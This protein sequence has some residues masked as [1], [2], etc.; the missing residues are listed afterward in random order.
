MSQ[1]VPAI[2][3]DMI[4][5]CEADIL[6]ESQISRFSYSH[7]H[8]S[9]FPHILILGYLPLNNPRVQVHLCD[10]QH[11]SKFQLYF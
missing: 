8:S 10:F 6:L 1:D 9:R 5:R 7:Y 2:W 4:Q 3:L 11:S